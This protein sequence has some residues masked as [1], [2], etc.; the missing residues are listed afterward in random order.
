[1]IDFDGFYLVPTDE[2]E[3]EF[4]FF[5]ATEGNDF[6]AKVDHTDIGDMYHVAF[7]R[8]KE[9]NLIFDECFD[10]IFADPVFYANGLIGGDI[11]ATF[12][13]K[14]TNS[15]EWWSDYLKHIGGSYDLG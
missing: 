2:G 14:T 15:S 6:G 12:M 13:R 10:A 4:K 7:F 1:M 5:K 11:Y 9:G 8:Y 3:V